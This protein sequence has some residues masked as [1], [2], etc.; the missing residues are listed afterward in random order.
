[1]HLENRLYEGTPRPWW[2]GPVSITARRR[3]APGKRPVER[4]H[5]AG[6]V[7]PL[8]VTGRFRRGSGAHAHTSA[9]G[10]GFP[11][12]AEL[13]LG[14][15]GFARQWSSVEHAIC[16]SAMQL[17]GWSSRPG[18]RD[19]ARSAPPPNALRFFLSGFLPGTGEEDAF[20]PDEHPLSGEVQKVFPIWDVGG[21]NMRMRSVGSPATFQIRASS[22]S[23]SRDPRRL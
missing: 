14:H 6:V 4:M 1:M 13:L 16:A 23:F 10:L 5:V 2:A 17:M 19:A 20:S 12:L 11:D 8:E 21:R 22:A 9:V 15:P 3:P 18:P 7:V